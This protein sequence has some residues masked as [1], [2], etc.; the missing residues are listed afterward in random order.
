MHAHAHRFELSAQTVTRLRARA[1]TVARRSLHLSA[2]LVALLRSFAAADL[3][4]MPLKGPVLAQQVYGAV[5]LRDFDDLDLLVNPRDV[6]RARE[7]LRS[8]GFVPTEEGSSP[9]DHD[10]GDARTLAF[11]SRDAR[12][13]LELHASLL[14]G[15]KS[16]RYALDGLECTV[17]D[18]MGAPA[19]TLMSAPMLAYLC[20]HGASHAWSRLEW[21]ATAAEAANAGSGGWDSA[22]QVSRQWGGAH[23]VRAARYLAGALLDR[24]RFPQGLPA[25]GHAAR[26]ACDAVVHRLAVAPD[27]TRASSGERFV[28]MVR[29]DAGWRA[30]L[31]RL[32]ILLLMPQPSDRRVFALPHAA[33][34]LYPLLRPLRLLG[35]ALMRL[36]RRGKARDTVPH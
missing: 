32:R 24:D 16:G 14:K 5:S 7:V 21:L 30:R 19:L 8:R 31:R 11:A 25:G 1:A 34:S 17:S 9:G 36:P 27:R 15:E 28:F 12:I 23:R 13:R 35:R 26:A 22:E 33:R 29:T 18:F 4:V 2:E 3:P 6:S 20:E 10:D